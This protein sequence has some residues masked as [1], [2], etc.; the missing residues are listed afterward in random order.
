MPIVD[1]LTAS[2]I[3]VTGHSVEQ[4]FRKRFSFPS[5]GCGGFWNQ[6]ISAP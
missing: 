4:L 3:E 1:F 5:Q 2:H 6:I